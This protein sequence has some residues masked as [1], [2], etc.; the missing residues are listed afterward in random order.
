MILPEVTTPSGD[1]NYLLLQ[2][3]SS[4]RKLTIITGQLYISDTWFTPATAGSGKTEAM[5]S[6]EGVPGRQGQL[7]PQSF[8]LLTP[9][10]GKDRIS[11]FVIA[12]PN[13]N[14]PRAF[15]LCGSSPTR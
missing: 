14:I 10:Q 3:V 6:H 1:F 11:Q 15:T 8:R 13:D 4:R 2:K 7:R 12:L 9:T 5:T